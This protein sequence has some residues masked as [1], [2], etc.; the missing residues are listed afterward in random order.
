MRRP[1][2]G[3]PGGASYIN[4]EIIDDQI[5]FGVIDKASGK[6]LQFAIGEKEHNLNTG[7][8]LEHEPGKGIMII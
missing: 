6:E 5:L 1:K 2:A 4:R 7:N 8:A 3:A